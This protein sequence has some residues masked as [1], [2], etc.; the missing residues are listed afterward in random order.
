[1]QKHLPMDLGIINKHQDNYNLK[2][3]QYIVRK[4]HGSELQYYKDKIVLPQSFVRPV[5]E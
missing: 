2:G 5:I 4:L 3:N 1:M